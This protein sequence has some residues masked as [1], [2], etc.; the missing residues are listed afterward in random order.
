MESVSAVGLFEA[1]IECAKEKRTLEKMDKVL[2]GNPVV[3]YPDEIGASGYILHKNIMFRL[4]GMSLYSY[5]GDDV[6]TIQKVDTFVNKNAL[7]FMIVSRMHFLDNIKKQNEEM[8]GY[9]DNIKLLMKL[10][11]Q[12]WK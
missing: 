4:E 1:L 11:D 12:I 5:F 2:E 8:E 6:Y 7:H 3:I 10:V 9:I